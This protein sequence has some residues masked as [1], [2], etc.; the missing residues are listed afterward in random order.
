MKR[1]LYITAFILLACLSSCKKGESVSFGTVEYYPSFLWVDSNITPVKKTFDFDFSQDAKDNNSFAEFCF[2]DNDDKPIS[3][4][5]MQVE[6]DGKQIPDNK[7]SV[8]SN[9]SSKDLVFKFSPKANNGK[10]QGY[11]KLVSHK[12]DRLDSQEL[13]PNSQVSAFQWTLR[14]D[15]VMNPLAK[16]LMWIG[17]VLVALLSLWLAVVKYFVYPRMKLSRIELTSRKGY[18]VNKKINGSRK[19][20]FT[21]NYKPQGWLNKLLTGEIVYIKD[22]LW[23]NPWELKPQNRT[24][25]IELHGKYMLSPITSV[26]ANFGTYQLENLETEE[27]I[28]IKIL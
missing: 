1:Y 27:I 16:V 25:K 20:V 15:K 3:T 13:Q 6:I 5:V 24:A 14:F 17:I 10:Y 2:V 19:V 11:L 18:Y 26:I 22:N 8:K 21:N 9:V 7:F 12:L 23:T 28:T 4:D